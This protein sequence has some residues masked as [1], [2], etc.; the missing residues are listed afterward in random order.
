MSDATST[1][2]TRSVWNAFHRAWIHFT[3]ACFV[4]EV[5]VFLSGGQ[6]SRFVAGYIDRHLARRV[7]RAV[8]L[9]ISSDQDLQYARKV[10][11]TFGWR[12]RY[13]DVEFERYSWFATSQLRMESLQGPF[14]TFGNQTALLLLAE[15]GGPFLSGYQD[16]VIGDRHPR[17]PIAEI[18]PFGFDD[19]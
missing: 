3:S 1:F 17:R 5:D 11:R 7:V 15:R 4:A 6:D 12:H 13:R 2:H 18:R 10:S 16:V 14:A 8:S 19:C 9:G